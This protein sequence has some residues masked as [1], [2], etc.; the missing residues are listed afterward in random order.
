MVQNSSGIGS[1]QMK[2]ANAAKGMFTD[3]EMSII[4]NKCQS[5]GLSVGEFMR[6]A[7]LAYVGMAQIQNSSGTDITQEEWYTKLQHQ[8]ATA[9]LTHTDAIRALRED[10]SKLKS[11]VEAHTRYISSL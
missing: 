8:I 2:K 7:A 11:D 5:L 3:E 9:N 4:K 6:Q 10:V 1:E